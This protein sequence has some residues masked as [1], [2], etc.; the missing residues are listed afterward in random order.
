ME[1]ET[2]ELQGIVDELATRLG[3][4]VAIDDPSIRLLAASR[5]FGDEDP[6]RIRVMLS[7][8]AERTVVEYAHSCGI[9][10]CEKP[11]RVPG[12]PELSLRPRICVPIRWSGLLLGYLWLID[13]DGQLT[14]LEIDQAVTAAD[15][16][17]M[18]LY[19]RM[20]LHERE[21]SRQEALL[22]DLVSTDV[23]ARARA[24][25]EIADSGPLTATGPVAVASVEIVSPP[26]GNATAEAHV[27]L[28]AAVE[29][30]CRSEPVGRTLA[31]AQP[32]RALLLYSA[33][34]SPES[35]QAALAELA[36]RALRVLSSS[37]N[38]TLRGVAGVGSVQADVDGCPVSYRHA[39][40]AA[41][42]AGLLRGF[43]PVATWDSLGVYAL[44][45]QLPRRDLVTD[46]CPPA[47]LRLVRNDPSGRLLETAETYLDC[48]GDATRAARELHIHRTTLHYRLGRIQAL[49]GSDLTNGSDRLSLHLGAKL[50]RLTGAY[51]NAGTSQA[52]AAVN[53]AGGAQHSLP[54]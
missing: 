32:R 13:P 31:Q 2:D 41:K 1:I 34:T 15:A 33:P 5:H 9:S 39:R 20:L 50:L 45:L 51:P 16:A 36:A 17:S 24:Q 37:T 10:R 21:R 42:V 46:L 25:D 8:Q 47:L 3:R 30:A 22:R 48:A 52:T 11:V 43:G 26:E 44:L 53:A 29:E 19:R 54:S 35:V 49:S 18:V 27:A 38:G 12:K 28:S 7:R 6:V 4:S 14:E 40:T 23:A